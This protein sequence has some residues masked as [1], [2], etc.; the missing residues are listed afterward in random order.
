MATPAIKLSSPPTPVKQ[1]NPIF[2]LKRCAFALVC[3]VLLAANSSP[4]ASF[5]EPATTFYGKILGIAS[6][7]AFPVTEGELTWTIRRAD[8]TDLTLRSP[9]WPVHRGEYSYRLQ[10]PHEA[11][12][13]GLTGSAGSVPLRTVD[14]THTHFRME[15]NGF[16]A[17]ILGPGG[18]TFDAAQV[19][20][21]SSYRLD[22]AVPLDAIDSDGEGLPD[23]WKRKYGILDPLAD[24]DGDGLNNLA[25]FRAGTDPHRDD[26]VPALRTRDIRVYAGGTTVVLLRA[27]DADSASE[28]LRYTLTAL[29]QGGSLHL[30]NARAGEG[31]HDL[32]LEIGA[33]F[34][35]AQVNR[36]RLVF[37]HQDTEA[38]VLPTSFQVLLQD[39][40]PAHPASTNIVRVHVYSPAP[41]LTQAERDLALAQLPKRWINLPNRS[42]AESA[43]LSSFLL[44]RDL[45]F[46][47]CDASAEV[48]GLE[49]ALPSSGFSRAN[50]DEEYV[51]HFGPDRPH[52]LLGGLG[53]DRLSGGMEDDILIGGAGDDRLRGNG[54]SDLFLILG[55]DSGNHTIE[56]FSIMENDAIDL[57]HV[58][59]GASSRLTD[60]LQIVTDGSDTFLRV[61]FSGSGSGYNDLLVTLQGVQFTAADL[62]ELV[63]N[64]HLRA[65]DKT[66]PS[67]ISIVATKPV[68][69]ENGPVAGEFTVARTGGVQ[70]S[71]TVPLRITGTAINGIDYEIVDSQ[72]TFPSGARTLVIPIVPYVDAITEL[73]EVVD[74][75]ILPGTHYELG[76]PSTARVTIEDLAPQVSIEALE[77]FAVKESQ[78]PGMFLVSRSGVLD[79]SVLVRLEIS[80]TAV[81]GVDYMRINTFLN[82]TAGQTSELL[83]I[84]PSLSASLPQGGKSV[85]VS[86]KP[87]PTYKIGH[88]A[89]ARILLVEEL[90]RLARWR[91]RH[92]ATFAGTLEAFA[93]ADPGNFGIPNL[94]RY[95]FG[96]DPLNPARARLPKAVIRD[97]YL[98]MDVWRNL[99]A[100]DID[101][102]IEVSSDM[103]S[104][105]HSP[106]WIE[107]ISPSEHVNDPS[108][109]SY[110]ALPAMGEEQKL[111]IKVRIIQKP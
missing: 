7:H 47:V 32:A 16:P 62:P 67:R 17:R 64:G 94:H 3:A 35:Q 77:G 33:S 87:D 63:D 78:T 108:V 23:W 98:T 41:R 76:T 79:R 92:F 104:W 84:I 61:N 50:Y 1:A 2:L 59:A 103:V 42:A 85:R 31:D 91:E 28:Q 24:P 45:G 49:L 6:D 44:S 11:L 9:L 36:G 111:F 60:Y 69:S 73:S 21:A 52:V 22:L 18:Y 100:S 5:T 30:R 106:A 90:L 39:E 29:P 34:T 4:A 96:L 54:G 107:E 51:R 75:A 53:N 55:R 102:A 14:D 65:G 101:F 88:P 43:I 72:V 68:A 20:R 99:Q 8:G 80:G 56:D 81:N 105:N 82:L 10:V 37:L 70:T 57:S 97:G 38:S 25:E 15:V 26:R 48:T 58:L 93:A 40:N 86:I 19:R 109:L 89:A 46:I 95:A 12:A 27:S 71:L 83:Q 74:I 13:L 66:L 110:R